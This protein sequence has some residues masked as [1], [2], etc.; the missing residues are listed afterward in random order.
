[1]KIIT[2]FFFSA[3]FIFL[4]CGIISAQEKGAIR[5]VVRDSTNMESLPFGNVFLKELNLGAST[6]NRGYFVIPSLPVKKTYTIIVSY[7][8][9]KTRQIKV[10]ASA[11]KVVD[12][13]ILLAPTSIQMNAIEKVE[14]LEKEQNLPDVSK[15]VMTP[16][17][18]EAMPKSVETD[19]L[20]S[21]TSL[22]GVQT[23]GDVSAKFNVRGGESNQNLILVDGIPLYYP[24]HAIGLFSVIDPDLVNNVEFFRGGFPVKY[25]RAISS[26]LNIL[27][28][29]GD[30]N[31][32]D[33]KLSASLLSA[34]GIIEGPIP[35]GSFYLS[36]RKSLSND[37]L[38]KFVNNDDLPIDFYDA[39]FKLNYA[40]PIFFSGSKFTIQ[41]LISEDNL[42]YSDQTRPDY[43]WA[44]NNWGFK[45]FSV[46]EV[47][48]F[49]DFGITLS[50]YENEIIPKLSGIKPK[51]NELTDFTISADFTYILDSKDEIG[52]GIDVKSVV[53]KLLLV[54]NL[55][56]QTDTGSEGVGSN[57]YL[58][59]KFLRF[60]NLGIDLGT[61][62]NIKDLAAKGVFAEPR[63][64]VSYILT[65]HVTLK[66]SAGVFQQELTT[67]QDEREVLSLFDPVVIIPAYLTKSKAYHYIFGI[68]SKVSEPLSVDIEGYYKKIASAPTL[69]ENKSTFDDPDLLPSTGES[70]G[71]ELQAKYNTDP[72]DFSASYTLSWAFKEVNGIRYVPRYDSRHNLNL[73][74]TFNLPAGWRLNSAWVYHSGFPF[75][76][77][78]GYY[79]N[80]SLNGL[81]DDYRIYQALSPTI[82]FD[83]KNE[84]RLP[85]YHRLD[86]SLSKKFN[87][88]FMKF[89]FDVSAINVYNRKN[90]F[91][92]EQ[93]TGKVVN[94]LPFLL[95]AT[96]KVEI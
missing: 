38:R 56:F 48:L 11:D 86:L 60:P 17:E 70:Y 92:F 1:M 58:N 23:V 54:S 66:S 44:N 95:T 79:D 90:I 62:L 81:L 85:D 24:F 84:A 27:T 68:S 49:L 59:Y 7:V 80:L 34:K 53:S 20:R 65:P 75:T 31:N 28:K 50:H 12:L 52:L 19:V 14:Y 71:G 69:N 13:E 51:S 63:I 57:A 43:R 41:S 96:V 47:P 74:V 93:N 18:I 21:L 94:M 77:Q 55:D 42:K 39:S 8:G 61:R 3:A 83:M 22:P 91:Y 16:K 45:V 37:I 4:S 9:Y 29:D 6:N 10:S 30:K 89:D 82:Y 73:S 76:Q 25:G 36:A 67:I 88:N 64:S 32:F 5:G 46:G 33:A 2:R 78:L 87:F 26:V 15:T 40:N 35:Y 72:V